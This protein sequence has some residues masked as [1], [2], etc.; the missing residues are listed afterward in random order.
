[1]LTSSGSSKPWVCQ[2]SIANSTPAWRATAIRCGGALVEPPIAVLSRTALRNASRVRICDGRKSSLTISTMRL[3][4]R[5][6]IV[7]RSRYGAGIAA[8]PG[9]AMPSPSASAFIVDAVP[10]VLQWPSDGA[11]EQT[12]SMNSS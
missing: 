7:A 6:A 10:I 4:V 11:A 1:M 8:L 5:Y 3:P 12:R 2:S 9:S